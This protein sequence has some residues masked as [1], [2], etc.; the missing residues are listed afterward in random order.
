L[1]GVNQ[2]PLSN[3]ELMGRIARGDE[4]AFE[5]LVH[6]HQKRILNLIYRFI[7]DRIQA[8][9]VAQEVFLKVWRFAK[10]YKVN[11][12]FTTWL[13]RIATNLCL[14]TLKSAYHKQTFVPHDDTGE[15]TDAKNGHPT[16]ADSS[17]SSP[18]DIL[19]A[20]EESKRIF[21]ALLELP[22]NQ[23]MAVILSKYDGLPYDEISRVLGC[24]ASAI[25]SL[26]VRAKKNLRKRL[27]I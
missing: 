5:I 9:D 27:S 26:L 1:N 22:E 21:N 10:D 20:T 7:G 25:E 3:E 13:Y 17:T 16:S 4:Q 14:D 24:S 12:Q 23:R 11:A 6:R 18:E 15:S 8:E 19:L 2:K